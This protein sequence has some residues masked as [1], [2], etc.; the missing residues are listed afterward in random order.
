MVDKGD[1]HYLEDQPE[2]LKTIVPNTRVNRN[3]GIHRSAKQ[4][5][6]FLDGQLKEYF[7]QLIYN[8][9]DDNGSI[10]KQ[11]F[12]VSRVLDPMLLEEVIRF[13]KEKNFDRVI[14]AQLAIALANKLNPVI[15]VR[16][17]ENDDRVAA[18]YSKVTGS[19][20][21]SKSPVLSMRIT[22]VKTSRSRSKLFL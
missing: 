9:T 16:S 22:G 3:K 19:R 12:G 21:R 20:N 1:G 18:Y 4:I 7:D 17:L 14:A 8:E 15:R 5:R 6:D 2:W 13:D 11:V 10:I